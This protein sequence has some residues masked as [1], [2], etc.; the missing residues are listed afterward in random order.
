[1]YGNIHYVPVVRRPSSV[2]VVVHRRRRPS[3]S[4]SA[5]VVRRRPSS[6]SVVVRRLSSVVHLSSSSFVV[7]V[8]RRLSS[9]FVV[10]Q[11]SFLYSWKLYAKTMLGNV[12]ENDEDLFWNE[13]HRVRQEDSIE[14]CPGAHRLVAMVIARLPDICMNDYV[15]I[16][17]IM[18]HQRKHK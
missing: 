16:R 12:G 11:I 1:M 6:S 8:R 13:S 3:S 15:H 17:Y 10:R 14:W 5:S 7:V 2:V 9:V 4:S 18:I